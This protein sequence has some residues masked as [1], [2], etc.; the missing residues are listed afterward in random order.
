VEVAK[1]FGANGVVQ[2]ICESDFGPAMELIT[3]RIGLVLR[4][5]AAR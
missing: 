1:G 4:A 5:R 2:S 3:R